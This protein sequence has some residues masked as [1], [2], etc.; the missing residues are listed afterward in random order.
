VTATFDFGARLQELHERVTEGRGE[1]PAGVRRAAARGHSLP[2]E[3]QT[4]A[5]KVRRHAY[6]IVDKDV[7]DLRAAGWSEDQIFELTIA[8]AM[9][10]GMSRWQHARRAL[11]EASR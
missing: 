8:I 7:E 5:E 9:G 10:E 11:A 2:G 3:A 1:L 4:Y 6:K